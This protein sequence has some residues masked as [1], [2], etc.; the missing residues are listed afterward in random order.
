MNQDE[1][2][3]ELFVKT[4]LSHLDLLKDATRNHI[5]R[6]NTMRIFFLRPEVMAAI[7]VLVVSLL[8]L[9][10]RS[11]SGVRSENN[12]RLLFK[13]RLA[14]LLIITNKFGWHQ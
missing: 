8:F 1:L 4:F 13:G 2:E 11:R 5:P 6:W 9:I 10:Q 7:S 3:D 14:D 12:K